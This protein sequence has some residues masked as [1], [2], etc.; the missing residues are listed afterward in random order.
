MQRIYWSLGLFGLAIVGTVTLAAP[1][2]MRPAATGEGELPRTL[3]PAGTNTPV[4]GPVQ[5]QPGLIRFRS[6]EAHF[7]AQTIDQAAQMLQAIAAAGERRFVIQFQAPIKPHE[8]TAL[9]ASGVKLLSYLSNHAF[10]ASISEGRFD[11]I[12]ATEAADIFMVEPI[13][14]RWKLHPDLAAGTVYEWMVVGLPKDA[15]ER[16]FDPAAL[17][18]PR[19]GAYMLFHGDVDLESEGV[20][21]LRAHGAH[22]RSLLRTVNGAVIE[23]PYDGLAALAAEDAVMWVEPPLPKFTEL[24]DSNRQITGANIVQAAPYGLS[25]AGVSVLVYDGGFAAAAHPDFGGRLFVRD[26]SGLSTHASHVSGTVGGSGQQS[27]GTFR[28]MAPAVTIQSYG[29]EQEGGLQQGFL[30]T[31]PGDIEQDYGQAINTYGADIANNSIGT[32]TAANGF[33]CDWEG[34]Y[35]VTDTVIDA[36]ARG[37]LSGEPFR[38]V[39]AAGNERGSGRCGTTYFTSA[40]PANAKNH[41]TVG[42]MNSNDDSVTSFT[43]WGPSDD[44][45]M[46]PDL[47]GPGCQSGG[48]NGVTSC[49]SGTG[50][51]TFC[52][53]SMA[54]PTVCGLGALLI[55]DFR[56]QFP[57]EP[58]MRGST[59]K[60]ILANTTQDIENVGPDYKTGMGSVRIQPAV[61]LLRAGNFFEGELDQGDTVGLVVIVGPEDAQ[62]RVTLAWDDPPGTPVVNPTLV[63]D[64]DLTVFDAANNAYYPWTLDPANPSAPA[65]RTQPNRRDNMEQ[66]TIDNPA[67]GAYRIE[68]TGFNVPM[69]PQPFSV[70]ASPLLVACS[71]AGIISLDRSRYPCGGTATIQ[72]VDC[73]L[74]TDD[75]VIDTVLVTIASSSE[76]GGETVL[77]TET[78]PESATFRGEI[79]LSETDAPGVLLIAPGDTITATYIDADDGEGNFDVEVTD[80]ATVDCTPPLIFDVQ[81]VDLQPRSA[82]ITF[83]T[84]E[85]TTARVRY[86]TSCGALSTEVSG[87]GI[88]TGHSIMLNG[89]TDEVTYFFEVEAADLA[90][91]LTVDDDGGA[92]YSFTTPDVPDFFTEQFSS[93]RDLDGLKLIFSPNGSVDYYGGCVEE[94]EALPTDPAGGTPLSLSDDSFATV[95]IGGGDAVHLYGAAY[96]TM[97]VGSNGYITFNSGDSTYTETLTAHFNQPRISGLF[98]DLNPAAGGQ[99]SW[100]KTEDRVAV[101]FL[102]VPEYGTSNQNTFQIEMFFN[103]DITI[104]H[105]VC[106]AQD[107]IV[108]LSAG[109]GLDPDFLPTDLS[110]MGA[111]GPRPPIAHSASVTIPANAPSPITL[112]ATDDGLP[113]P[114]ALSFVIVSLPSHGTLRDAGTGGLIASVPY[115][116]VE[117]GDE[118]I[119]DPQEW[120][121]APVSFDFKANDGGEPPDGGDSNI[122]TISVTITPPDAELVYE[123]PLDSDPGWTT[124]GQW[125]WGVPSGG[126]R[127]GNPTSGY[128]GANVYGYN[129]TG[130]YPNNMPRYNLTTT[131]IDCSDLLSVELRFW[132]WL[133]VERLPFDH[134]AVEASADGVNWTLLWENTTTIADEVWAPQAFDLTSLAAE[135]PTL[136]VR[137]G[138]G[139]TDGSNRYPGWS[140]DDVEIW[141]IVRTPSQPGDVNGDGSVDLADLSLLLEAFGTC[142][143][144]PG[145]NPAADFDGNG[146]V[147]L[148]DL[149]TLL[150]H[151]GT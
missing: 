138:M 10:F 5:M 54:S 80:T 70:A 46:R 43:S 98:D 40:P 84:D 59:L 131:A 1:W 47:S 130:D 14:P 149:S 89:L 81:V 11:P 8:R 125:A 42:A 102:N 72:V 132:R 114:A 128:T 13:D 35:G 56:Q 25:G 133:G 20:A 119:Y 97:Y 34:N 29:F 19:V 78:A 16:G 45:R 107:G 109:N 71:D 141:G 4:Q 142:D 60:V 73:G 116:L 61:D 106:A 112:T 65:V 31:D 41:I 21:I 87:L 48:D 74:N 49:N 27:G 32:N 92:C 30:Y 9:E 66:L 104:T 93:G 28:G 36:I 52:G 144:D 95:P 85:P 64:L 101:T 103:G 55:E 38:I 17:Q 37:S 86:G 79:E 33:P 23:M 94:I 83:S 99:V 6:G 105:L 137:W 26:S 126:S 136:Y 24:N 3:Q 100:K 139:P 7:A 12:G 75:G 68:I 57:G 123:W 118:V 146:C 96:T 69:G 110:A 44:G 51:T 127:N 147:D 120:N 90:G 134:A 18:N 122:A 140:I 67:P 15:Y 150:E 121:F 39:W 143:G 63:N 117:N 22:V 115:T 77:L 129:L 53:T 88:H 58:D 113:E 148:G 50:Y 62:L 82:R 111:C 2:Q 76:P 145:Y 151:F 124:E 135:Q 108:G 91:N